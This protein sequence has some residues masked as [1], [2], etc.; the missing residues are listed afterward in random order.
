MLKEQ[1]EKNKFLVGMLVI[2][3]VV[4]GTYYYEFREYKKEENNWCVI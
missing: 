4:M 2:I 3:F 1:Y